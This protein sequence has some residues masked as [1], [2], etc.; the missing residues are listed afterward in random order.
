MPG[1][2]P[3][4]RLP[5]EP[6]A[7]PLERLAVQP[8]WPLLAVMFVGPWM[9][10][11]WFL[12][13]SVALGAPDRLKTIALVAGG[14]LGSVVLLVG[15]SAA[16]EAGLPPAAVPYLAIAITVWK[17]GVSYLLHSWQSR[18]VAVHQLYGGTLASGGIPL[19]IGWYGSSH[20]EA[21]L[22]DLPLLSVALTP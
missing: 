22:A 8:F 13:N 12:I 16:I 2:A 20:V 17:L 1:S 3:T 18:T 19:L 21:A 14:F 10:W 5:D 4:Y 6:K 15:I 7:S 9:S 11:L